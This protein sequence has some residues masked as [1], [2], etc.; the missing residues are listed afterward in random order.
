MAVMSLAADWC[1]AILPTVKA[2]AR[3]GA[4]YSIAKC[5]QAHGDSLADSARRITFFAFKVITAA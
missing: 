5:P 3:E 2:T 1:M 4:N